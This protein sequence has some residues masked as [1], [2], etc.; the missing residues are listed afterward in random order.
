[1][2]LVLLGWSADIPGGKTQNMS[3][4]C[5]IYLLQKATAKQLTLNHEL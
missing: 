4:T 2:A 3:M 5:N 1:M